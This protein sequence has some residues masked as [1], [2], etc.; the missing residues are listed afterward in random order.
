MANHQRRAAG[1]HAAPAV[2]VVTAAL[3]ALCTGTVVAQEV[4]MQADT[5]TAETV[6]LHASVASLKSWDEPRP[7]ALVQTSG[8]HAPGDG[9]GALYRVDGPGDDVLANEADIIA[10]KNGCFAVLLA[11]EAVN[12]RMFGAVGDG[13]ND[14]GVQIKLAHEYACRHRV[15]I[16][17]LSGEF[18]IRQAN[19]IPIQTN[20]SWGNTIF[21]L[22]ERF[23]STRTP[24]FVVLSDEPARTL[25]LDEELKSAL[26]D[27]IRPGVQIIPELAD[28]AGHLVVVA[29]SEDRIG[30]RAGYEG[31]RGWARE[32]F[33]YVEEEG[34][35]IG[36]IAWEFRDFTSVTVSRCS[37]TYLVIEGGG[38]YVSGDTPESETAGYHH[39]GFSIQRSRT[40]VR[41]QWMG[42][43][44]GR[45]DM[46]LEPRHGFY[47]LSRVYDVTLEDIRAMPWEKGRRP[48]EPPVAHGTYGIGGSR[49]LHCT[50]RNLTAEA[51]PVAWGVLGTNLIKNVRFEGCHLNRIDVHFH[52]WNLYIK[53]CVIGLKG[54]SVTG[55][56]DLFVED[57]TRVGNSFISF[58][59][60]YGSKWDG[61][62]RLRGCTLRPAGP[63]GVNVLDFRMADFDY[64]YPIGYGRSIRIEDLVIDYSA[65][66]DASAPC[67]LM[68]AV[69][70]S[71]TA[72]GQR[73]F[74]PTD[75]AFEDIRVRGREQGV[76]LLRIARPQQYEV[77]R[78]G[79]YDGDRL[80]PNC[81]LNVDNV[82]LEQ[83]TPQ[84]PGDA[85]SVHLLLGEEEEDDYL[86]ERALYPIVRIR[87]C[88]GVTAHLGHSVAGALFER[89]SVNTVTAP[90]L[91]G[92]LAFVG[93]R[94]QPRV[95]ELEG[96][97]YRL[98]STLGTRFTDCTV[99][100]PVVGGEDRPDLVDR[101][102][103]VQING[104]VRHHHL[105]TALSNRVLEHCRQAGVELE[106]GFI[107][108]LRA[109]NALEP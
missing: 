15:P 99:H 69:P 43:E 101:T 32:E 34:Y 105:N 33:F 57:T 36:D 56:G 42:L 52:G 17:N 79:G 4:A 96:D 61:R 37:P 51:G 86:D 83:L 21:H 20:V 89:C 66:P 103:F 38:F 81:T 98:D 100:A 1:P 108:R 73:L 78:A 106:P 13:E 107:A 76:R 104:A 29:D 12:Y 44:P 53:D 63:G 94:F 45:R 95:Q 46:S 84:R 55:G 97:I 16:V 85:G 77:A 7:G 60:D 39:N 80:T 65:V 8:F 49:M 14:D 54:I 41:G 90:G 59:R 70:F 6:V 50:F 88:E 19:G 10:L 72:T 68:N 75:I 2:V 35:I 87:D 30:I 31:N 18:W 5:P 71:A 9:G 25:E 74:W 3:I 27:K 22:D 64:R 26:L 93:C 11:R 58:R 62:I 109:Q 48:P 102:G 92:E 24:R 82:Q 28:Y 40:I 91:R 47:S 23:N 67:W